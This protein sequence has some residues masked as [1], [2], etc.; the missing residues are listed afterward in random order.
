[1]TNWMPGPWQIADEDELQD[2]KSG[3]DPLG[4]WAEDGSGELIRV[5]GVDTDV[6]PDC[7]R[8]NA[9]LI[10]AAPTMVVVLESAKELLT[11]QTRFGAEELT[12]LL[13]SVNHALAAAKGEK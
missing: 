3:E 2:V 11:R 4:I 10:A 7:I 8:A 9:H 12:I 13:E 1:M 6:T 5:C